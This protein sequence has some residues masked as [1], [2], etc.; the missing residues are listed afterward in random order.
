[1]F[2]RLPELRATCPWVE[3]ADSLPTPVEALASLGDAWGLPA[4]YTKREDLTCTSYGGNKVRK[5]EWLLGDVIASERTSVLTTGAWGSHHAYATALYARQ[6]GIKCTVVCMPQPPTPHVANMF[7]ATTE[8]ATRVVRAHSVAMVPLALARARAAATFAGEGWPYSI[9]PGGSNARG[10]LGYVDFALELA[11]QV[12]D[13]QLPAPRFIHVAAGT[14]GTAAGISLGMALA[15]R[16]VPELAQVEVIATRVVPSIVA[17]MRRMRAL[18]RGAARLLRSCGADV[19]EAAQWSPIRLV[20]DQLGD[21]YGHE[22]PEGRR[23][24]DDATS[25]GGLPVEP[26][27]TAKALAGLRTFAVENDARRRAVHLWIHTAATTPP[28][29]NDV[30]DAILPA[31]LRSV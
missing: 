19:P 12:A 8:T 16:R 1:L 9:P 21:G 30:D 7:A 31:A 17:N 25:I 3:L 2:E 24:S 13:G 15:A 26:T 4:L 22:T 6:L 29:P 5:L 28:W 20:A 14:C 18:Q 11:D 27:Y 23:A 10:V